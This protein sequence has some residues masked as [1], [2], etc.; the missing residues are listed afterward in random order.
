MAN[1]YIWQG[2]CNG[3]YTSGFAC[4]KAF[5]KKD[6]IK[7][8]IEKVISDF[9]LDTAVESQWKDLNE[10][11]QQG[12]EKEEKDEY[13]R[14]TGFPRSHWEELAPTKPIHLKEFNIAC[15][16]GPDNSKDLSPD[17]WKEFNEYR[18]S[19]AKHDK[20]WQTIQDMISQGK[21]TATETEW[22]RYTGKSH[23]DWLKEMKY[24]DCDFGTYHCDIVEFEKELQEKEPKVIRINDTFEFYQGGGD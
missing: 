21:K 16:Y 9:K 22:V 20:F 5:S 13:I 3:M 12:K 19:L 2:V 10:K 8:I 11:I 7:N 23:D 4:A 17:L 14:F 6:A 18:T 24:P 15:Q 1:L